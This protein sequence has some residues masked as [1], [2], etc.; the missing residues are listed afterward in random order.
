MNKVF[1]VGLIGCGH[2]S[3]TYFRA[4]KYFNN[5]KI[6]KCADINYVSAI[7]CAK[8]FKIKALSVKELLKDK[9]VEIILNLT[10]PKAHYQVA[11]LA[12]TNGKHIYSEKPLAINFKDGKD[13][14]KLSKKKKLY[15]GN[16]PD[17]FLGGGIQK[18]KELVE[19]KVIG[20]VHLGNAFFA[21]P[22][23]QSYHPN[24]EPWF[25][26]K[27]GGPVIDMGPYYLTALVNLLGPAK[28]VSGSIVKGVKKR[29][30]GIGP[31]KNKTFKVQCP[32]TYL[33]TITFQNGTV[34]RLTLSFDV[35][36]HQK[37]HIELYG[38]KGSMIVP[39][40]NMFGGS[41]YVCKKFGDIWKEYKTNKMLL[42]KINIRSQSSRANESSINANYRGVGL[43]E[44][45]YSIE[46]KKVNKCNGELS[47]HVLDI[48]QST[49]KAC[50]TGIPQ[51]IKTTCKKPQ[52]FSLKKIRK[53]IK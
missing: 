42:G 44:M 16:A 8:T 49:M 52:P 24:P 34:V 29:T 4:E 50:K 20:K 46:N 1:K 23:V 53:I 30:I 26:K 15:I 51:S 27:E 6:I 41:V 12:L 17:T 31:R 9:E 14:L 47:L 28:K 11:K 10:I 40:P 5:I 13:L 21:F 45:A 33:S 39:D 18:S 3:E 36:A 48:I 19:K 25:A 32:T 43:A 38:K 37:N 22:G 2:I 7:K 35:I